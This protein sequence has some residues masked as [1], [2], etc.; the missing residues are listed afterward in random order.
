M[1]SV[2]FKT[3]RLLTTILSDPN[4]P[5]AVRAEAQELQ[6][7]KRALEGDKWVYRM[8]V[9]FLGM[10]IITTVCGGI[11]LSWGASATGLP[12]GIVAI[13]S[14]AVGAL[15]GLLAPSPKS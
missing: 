2:D 10:A 6:D 13:G 11:L 1:A 12:D 15:A 14:A 4:L 7:T 9:G 5:P 3:D 8:V